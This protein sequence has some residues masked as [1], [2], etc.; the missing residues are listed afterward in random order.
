MKNK[1]YVEVIRIFWSRSRFDENNVVIN[2]KGSQLRYYLKKRCIFSR[3]KILEIYNDVDSALN[4]CIK[5]NR[6]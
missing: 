4:E 1:Y 5:L 3:D 6:E 2:T